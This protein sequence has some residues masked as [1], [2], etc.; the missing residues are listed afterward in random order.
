MQTILGI[1]GFLILMAYGIIQIY[2]GFLGLQ[3]EFGTIWAWIGVIFTF[4]T[5]FTLII[6]GA[7]FIGALNVWEW[8]WALSALFAA[9]GLMLF[10]PGVLIG[11][12]SLVKK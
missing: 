3:Y 1:L 2:A 11:I 12:L 7:S 6:T 8:H 4:M 5:R 10:I 9:P